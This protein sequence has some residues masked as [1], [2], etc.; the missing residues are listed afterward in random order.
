MDEKSD[1]I[2]EKISEISAK[3]DR[4]ATTSEEKNE[5]IGTSNSSTPIQKWTSIGDLI[6]KYLSITAAIV[7]VSAAFISGVRIYERTS[8]LISNT[9]RRIAAVLEDIGPRSAELYG[10]G[11]P[12]DNTI[13]YIISVVPQNA[14][15]NVYYE[16]TLLGKILVSIQ[17]AP[18][19]IIGYSAKG[20][21][22]FIDIISVDFDG[23]PS[24]ARKRW[25]ETPISN[26]L[27][28]DSVETI[29]ASS[30]STILHS[31][32][33]S[34]NDC[35][36]AI[37]IANYLIDVNN[38]DDVGSLWLYPTFLLIE[39]STQFTEFKPNF[40]KGAFFPCS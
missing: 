3:I 19:K 6:L 29:T 9:E 12:G 38:S 23:N 15:N 10:L 11:G 5:K 18:G 39:E 4:V 40:Q 21:G 32:K 26:N 27:G 14:A 36:S 17:G 25:N 7:S 1:Q 33:I 8:E 28:Q 16:I 35:Y 34:V 20:G 22:R 24:A 2:L 37:K 31:W 30:S 13:E